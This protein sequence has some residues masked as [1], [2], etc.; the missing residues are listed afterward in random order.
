MVIVLEAQVL[1]RMVR[2]EALT[3]QTAGSIVKVESGCNGSAT[4][5][6]LS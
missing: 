5:R 1:K 2:Q 3:F 4:K 6:R